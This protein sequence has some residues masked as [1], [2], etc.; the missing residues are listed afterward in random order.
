MDNASY[1]SVVMDVLP[2][3]ST[4]GNK[5][6]GWLLKRVVEYDP[7]ET[8]PELLPQVDLHKI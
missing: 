3:R 6:K 2:N 7:L 1:C 8:I 4:L 5:I